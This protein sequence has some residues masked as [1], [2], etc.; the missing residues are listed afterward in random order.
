MNWQEICEKE[1][2]VE[3]LYIYVEGGRGRGS[4]A[5]EKSRMTWTPG[6]GAL[7]TACLNRDKQA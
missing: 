6:N 3:S 2:I 7:P 1:P 4:R 5:P